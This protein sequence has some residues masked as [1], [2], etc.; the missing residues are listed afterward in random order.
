[1]A[2]IKSLSSRVQELTAENLRLR[3]QLMETPPAGRPDSSSMVASSA[4][5]P[6]DRIRHD[7][8]PPAPTTSRLMAN[9]QVA[10]LAEGKCS[11]GMWD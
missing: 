3:Q 5:V 9:V 7:N 10:S 4:P 11:G 8:A 1:M 2:R 6:T